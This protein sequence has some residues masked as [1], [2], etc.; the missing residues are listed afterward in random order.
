MLLWFQSHFLLEVSM[1]HSL[2]R[3][4]VCALLTSAI[5]LAG[6]PANACTRAVYHGSEGRYLTGR[7]FDWKAEIVSNL[8][9]C[10]RGMKRNG[11]AGPRSV[12]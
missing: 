5:L 2:V 8:W 9:I 6:A 7:T 10:P 4:G 12:E 11:A 3:T 1:L